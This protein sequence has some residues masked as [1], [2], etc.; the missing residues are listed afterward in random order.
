MSAI[1]CV[2]L[3]EQKRV[4]QEDIEVEKFAH[5]EELF[6]HCDPS[7]AAY[8]G[9]HNDD[10]VKYGSARNP[11]WVG[12]HHLTAEKFQIDGETILDLCRKVALHPGGSYD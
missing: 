10:R 11:Q 6:S 7:L 9:V 8:H 3:D 4:V 2:T 1:E 12:I 5:F